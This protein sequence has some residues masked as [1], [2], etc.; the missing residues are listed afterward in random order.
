MPPVPPDPL[1]ECLDV[2]GMYA[3]GA[4]LFMEA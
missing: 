4:P 3:A 2:V 1:Q